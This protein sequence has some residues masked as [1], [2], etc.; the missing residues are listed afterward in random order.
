MGNC[1]GYCAGQKEDDSGQVRQ[2]FNQKDLLQ[3]HNDFEAKY[4]KP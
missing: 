2:Q 4:G 3:K 1:A